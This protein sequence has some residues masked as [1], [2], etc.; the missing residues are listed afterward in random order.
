M[1]KPTDDHDKNDKQDPVTPKSAGTKTLPQGSPEAIKEELKEFEDL[2]IRLEKFIAKALEGRSKSI[3][4][5]AAIYEN[6]K[7]QLTE[8]KE[9]WAKRANEFQSKNKELEEHNQNLTTEN[10]KIKGLVVKLENE[11]NEQKKEFEEL[12]D[13]MRLLK[14][15]RNTYEK[16]A[17][18][19]RFLLETKEKEIAAKER[20]IKGHIDAIAELKA[21]REAGIEAYRGKI[22]QE[23][24]DVQIQFL[25]QF[26]TNKQ[27]VV[28]LYLKKEKSLK[29]HYDE[30]KREFQKQ[31]EEVH[32]KLKVAQDSERTATVKAAKLQVECDALSTQYNAEKE[33]SKLT[34]EKH[35]HD[36]NTADQAQKKTKRTTSR[37]YK[38][39]RL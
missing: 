16:V 13:L 34:V 24:E 29:E 39:V 19:R 11:L 30:L 17:E 25:K 7:N 4:Y 9:Q 2:N 20:E 32:N 10:H 31:I 6:H 18:E 5:A 33:R 37:A 14:S 21:E 12:H 35:K 27:G 15:E 1:S 22:I 8:V 26:E 38:G 36:K 3:P 23:Y 28:E